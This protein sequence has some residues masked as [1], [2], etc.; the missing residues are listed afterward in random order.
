MRGGDQRNIRKEKRLVCNGVQ[1]FSC[2]LDTSR[3]PRV[4]DQK[5]GS[6]GLGGGRVQCT[7]SEG[8]KVRGRRFSISGES[9]AQNSE[10][11]ALDDEGRR[12]RTWR[13]F[14]RAQDAQKGV[15]K[16]KAVRSGVQARS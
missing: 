6:W 15:R 11:P 4:L 8:E 3:E 10:S 13:Q 5:G 7:L 1:T 12:K 9:A 14:A 2:R 16:G